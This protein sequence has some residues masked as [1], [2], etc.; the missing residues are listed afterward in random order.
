[1]S[2]IQVLFIA[3]LIFIL[4]NYFRR[5]RSMA[6]DKIL[7]SLMLLSGIFFVLYPD[8]TTK[9]ARYLGIGRGTDLIFYLAILGFGYM[10]L[11]L[12]SKIKNLEDQITSL[13]RKQ[14]LENINTVKNT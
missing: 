10:I 14:A 6:I 11:V 5:F 1:M 3:A 2:K 9:I 7:I 4:I 12:Y 13:V 8:L